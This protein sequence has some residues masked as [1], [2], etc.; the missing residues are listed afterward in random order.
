MAPWNPSIPCHPSWKETLHMERENNANESAEEKMNQ[1][2]DMLE[3]N[4][5]EERF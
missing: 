4:A 2:K 3:E 5:Y 1:V